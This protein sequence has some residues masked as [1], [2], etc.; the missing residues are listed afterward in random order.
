MAIQ[1]II[2]LFMVIIGGFAV[3]GSYV[4]GVKNYKGRTSLLW[5]G[6]PHSIRPAYTVSMLLAA[7]GYFFFVYPILFSVEPAAIT[8]FG[9]AG[10]NFFFLILAFILIPSAMWMP[11]TSVYL[12]SPGVTLRYL[13]RAI[14]AMVGLASIAMVFAI[15]TLEPELEGACYYLAL[16]GSTYFAFHTAV[17]DGIIWS[18]LLPKQAL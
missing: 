7:S 10:F 5:G 16:A 1:Q 9:S 12:R 2:L 4:L 13:I 8:V 15:F 6:I 18:A 11:L 17:L 3:L 14:L